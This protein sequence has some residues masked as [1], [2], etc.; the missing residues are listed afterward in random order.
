M[1]LPRLVIITRRFWPAA[2]GSERMLGNLAAE[3]AWRGCRV[4]V[5][6]PAWDKKWS[7]HI[8]FR[9]ASVIR[10][11]KPHSGSFGSV[12]YLRALV[13]WLR[14]NQAAYD[15]VYVSSLREE[16]RAAVDNLRGR[17]PV[18]LRAERAGQWGDCLWQLESRHGRKI[19]RVCLKADALIGP[20]RALE[21]ELQAAGYPRDR[22]RFIPHGF[23][24]APQR[25]VQQQAVARALLKTTNPLMTLPE[26]A[27]GELAPLAVYHGRLHPAQ[28]VGPLLDVWKEVVR[29]MPDARLWL[30]GERSDHPD[31][32][33]QI[34]SLELSQRVIPI[35]GFDNPRDLLSAA[36]LF[37]SAAE[38][39]DSLPL[40]EAMA[41]GLPVVA[42]D[43]EGNRAVV[44]G[45]RQ[46][47]L[48]PPHQSGTMADAVCR[49][50][51][52]AQLAQEMGTAGK[53]RAESEFPLAKMVDRHVTL[54]EELTGD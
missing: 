21:R 38:E 44:T 2:G 53:I 13:R 32:L 48:T 29:R 5:L 27:F 34:Q 11:P 9:G 25:D 19:K 15:V 24:T 40:V 49:L 14:N 31:L 36:D 7:E 30:S 33:E 47:L 50:L 12:R 18:L 45:G 17:K 46:G 1:K 16:A 51:D 23:P 52:D 37:V 20:S 42:F 35:G 39:D 4:T 41:A 43:N 6:T 26:K 22:I 28:S 8:Y 10:L 3:L 54:L